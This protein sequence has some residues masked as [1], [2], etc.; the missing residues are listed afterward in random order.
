M[1][2]Q[3]PAAPPPAESRF[4][5]IPFD[6]KMTIGNLIVLA[7]LALGGTLTWAKIDSTLGEFGRRI[8]RLE[9][10][11]L[12]DDAATLQLRIDV[13]A[14]LATIEANLNRLLT[15]ASARTSAGQP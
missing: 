11:R 10:Q 3:P 2:D 1:S 5:G 8:E 4:L 9:Q 6:P 7:G 13:A 14:R 15:L 12:A